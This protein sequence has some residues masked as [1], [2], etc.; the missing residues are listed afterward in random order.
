ME[1]DLIL[2]ARWHL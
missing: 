2:C 1:Y